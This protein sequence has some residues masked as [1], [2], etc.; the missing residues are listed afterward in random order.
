M[1]G[2]NY[3]ADASDLLDKLAEDCVT[4]GLKGK[5]ALEYVKGEYKYSVSLRTL[6]RRMEKVSKDENIN[7]WLNYFTRVGFVKL[8][9]EQLANIEMIQADSIKRYQ[10]LSQQDPRD[11]RTLAALKSDIRQNA[12]LLSEFSLGTPVISAIKQKLI[13]K[14][15]SKSKVEPLSAST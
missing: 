12:Q 6:Q 14:E 13:K 9:K 7:S 4:Y 8:H 11:E 5:Q 10:E 15:E 3:Q 2:G 1:A